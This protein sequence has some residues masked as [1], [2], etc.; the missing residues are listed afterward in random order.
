VLGAT[1]EKTAQR[2]RRPYLLPLLG[3][4]IVL[5]GLAALPEVA[6]PE[7]RLGYLLARH[8]LELAGLGAAVLASVAITLL[9]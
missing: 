3:L 2:I 4:A 5:L 7:P 6:V 1:A 8:R 9:R